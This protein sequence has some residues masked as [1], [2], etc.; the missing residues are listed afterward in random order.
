MGEEI[1]LKKCKEAKSKWG[2]RKVHRATGHTVYGSDPVQYHGS[3]YK[4]QK[5]NL[6]NPKAHWEN[7]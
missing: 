5:L 1:Y 7:S 4:N 6:T 3:G 2:F